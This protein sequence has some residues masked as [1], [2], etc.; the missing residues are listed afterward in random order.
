MLTPAVA[1]KAFQLACRRSLHILEAMCA[2]QHIEFAQRCI[3]ITAMSFSRLFAHEQ[4]FSGASLEP[5]N[6]Q[7]DALY[8]ARINANSAILFPREGEKR[9]GRFAF[10]RADSARRV[11]GPGAAGGVGFYR[12]C[13]SSMRLPKGSST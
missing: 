12:G 1:D 7:F 2:V 3:R 4:A 10:G 8:A 5:E 9:G 11:P 13:M 6:H